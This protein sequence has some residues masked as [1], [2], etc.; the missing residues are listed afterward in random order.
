M[1]HKNPPLPPSKALALTV[2]RFLHLHLGRALF[3]RVEDTLREHGFPATVAED[4]APGKTVYVVK[5]NQTPLARWYAKV[6]HLHFDGTADLPIETEHTLGT[7]ENW[8]APS[9]RFIFLFRDSPYTPLLSL[10][11]TRDYTL[12][13]ELAH[14]DERNA[15]LSPVHQEG[16]ADYQALCL[17][18]RYKNRDGLR[19]DFLSQAALR[20]ATKAPF[21]DTVLYLDARLKGETPPSDPEI[22]KAGKD[23]QALLDCF[24]CAAKGELYPGEGI[25]DDLAL[26]RFTLLKKAQRRAEERLRQSPAFRFFNVK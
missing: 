12:L 13:H 10:P 25:V 22:Q 11:E 20:D 5:P 23:A 7:S 18:E 19:T 17:M 9:I 24:N 21:H 2:A 26:T 6:R 16:D 3:P 14:C 1:N 4:L 15:R 8:G